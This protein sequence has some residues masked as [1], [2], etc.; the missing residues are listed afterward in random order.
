M[1]TMS[2][3]GLYNYDNSIFDLMHLPSGLNKETFIHNLLFEL[4]E[5]EILYTNPTFL[6]VAIEKWSAKE[7]LVWEKLYNTTN[8]EYNPI[9]NYDRREEW[10]DEGNAISRVAAFN[11][12]D[13]VPA[14][15]GD[16]KSKHLG[17]THGNIGVTTTQAMIKEE[18]AVVQF[19]IYDHI[20]GSFKNRFCILVY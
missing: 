3:L 19:N 15:D 1:A 13:L 10:E 16:T 11:E 9:E 4:A 12:S 18:R 20:I 6:K 5:L 14:G 7:F 17:R 2:V 8:F